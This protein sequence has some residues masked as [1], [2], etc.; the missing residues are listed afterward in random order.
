VYAVHKK[1]GVDMR[2]AAF[3]LAIRR[4]LDAMK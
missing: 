4:V 2:T 3:I 1:Y